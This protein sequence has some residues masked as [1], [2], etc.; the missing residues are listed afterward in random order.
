MYCVAGLYFC[1]R[2]KIYS[3]ELDKIWHSIAKAN[4]HTASDPYA[5]TIGK[6]ENIIEFI[7]NNAYI[8]VIKFIGT[9]DFIKPV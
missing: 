3:F 5:M 2:Y 4:F 7:T 1:N 8:V 6:R 9:P